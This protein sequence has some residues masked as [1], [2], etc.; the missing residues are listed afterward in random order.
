MAVKVMIRN[1]CS[2]ISIVI[3]S[4]FGLNFLL[5]GDVRLLLILG[6]EAT[7]LGLI[8][9]LIENRRRKLAKH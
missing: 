3:N 5:I 4:F 6:K 1:S 9:V 7:S 8:V 2:K